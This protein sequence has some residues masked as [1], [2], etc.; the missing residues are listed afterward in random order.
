MRKQYGTHSDDGYSCSSCRN[1]LQNT[2]NINNNGTLFIYSFP[3]FCPI[4]VGRDCTHVLPCWVHLTMVI[5]IPT[6]STNNRFP[7]T[8]RCNEVNK[9]KII[10]LNDKCG[11]IS[12]KLYCR[13]FKTCVEND[14]VYIDYLSFQ[15]INRYDVGLILSLGFISIN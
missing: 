11:G 15:I 13:N 5:C 2:V 7:S 4:L 10:I 8:P 6:A 9:I 14:M 1:S 12:A 3:P